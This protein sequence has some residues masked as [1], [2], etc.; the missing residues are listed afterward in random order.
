MKKLLSVL[1]CVL[2]ALIVFTP[3]CSVLC[4][5][6]GYKF[7]LV[8]PAIF[9]VSI[10][11]LAAITVAVSI[12]SKEILDNRIVCILVSVL[13]P[14]AMLN[15]GFYIRSCGGLWIVASVLVCVACGYLTIRHGKPMSVKTGGLVLS[16]G[17][18][19]PM[20]L[21]CFVLLVAGK[22]QNYVVLETVDSP[23]GAYY[24]QIIDNDQGEKGGWKLVHIYPDKDIVT[25]VFSIRKKHIKVFEAYYNAGEADEKTVALQWT[26]DRHL[27]INGDNYSF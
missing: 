20:A 25:P 2:L 4:W 3:L 19:L 1:V 12:F 6:M 23:S 21:I 18:L 5:V 22:T 7:T 9:A 15:T 14:C 13:T 8:D 27:T 26:D 24:A 16:A 17:L 11:A 10:F